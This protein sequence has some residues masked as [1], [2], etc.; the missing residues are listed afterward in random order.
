VQG[1]LGAELERESGVGGMGQGARIGFSLP[2]TA[3]TV[4]AAATKE[5]TPHICKATGLAPEEI[6]TVA[7]YEYGS[8]SAVV[9]IASG[10]DLKRMKVNPKALV[11]RK[12]MSKL[13][14][15]ASTT[16]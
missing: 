5:L 11:R 6:L 9:Q 2:I 8:P 16:Q 1:T 12:E 3:A 15:R 7:T 14:L 13:T 10:V 4:D